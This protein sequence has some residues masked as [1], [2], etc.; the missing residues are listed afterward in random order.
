MNLNLGFRPMAALFATRKR[1][2]HRDGDRLDDDRRQ[3]VATIIVARESEEQ[4]RT[5]S[6]TAGWMSS[7]Q[8]LDAV[9]AP[10]VAVPTTQGMTLVYRGAE[11]VFLGPTAAVVPITG[12]ADDHQWL[13]WAMA[14]NRR[15]PAFVA[16]RPPVY[17]ECSRF[18]PVPDYQIEQKIATGEIVITPAPNPEA[19]GESSIDLTLGG[20]FTIVRDGRYEEIKMKPGEVI[21]I[22]PGEGVLGCT[23]E[24][25]TLPRTI[26]ACLHT[27]SS[28]ARLF[29]SVHRGA[30]WID[31]GTDR[32]IALEMSALG[33]PVQ[34]EVGER[35][36]R[37]VLGYMD[38]ACRTGYC[39]R[40]GGQFSRHEEPEDL[41]WH[42]RRTQPEDRRRGALTPTGT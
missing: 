6:T 32:F 30:G 22:R 36:C 20:D 19:I 28:I 37:I 7:D 16:E 35:I 38:A 33:Q 23:Q 8:L 39:K 12:R 40:P 42:A 27:R 26:A 14:R 34:L 31:A 2:D 13:H 15:H 41:T 21:E 24:W 1:R 18:M 9:G 4:F 3:D 17:C 11:P 5:A 25:V 29:V 10:L